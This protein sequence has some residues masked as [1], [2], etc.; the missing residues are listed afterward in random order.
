MTQTT[1][2]FRPI[3]PSKG[4]TAGGSTHTKGVDTKRVFQGEKMEVEEEVNTP[5]P[6]L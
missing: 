4:K 1:E 6:K 3:D 5:L 2:P